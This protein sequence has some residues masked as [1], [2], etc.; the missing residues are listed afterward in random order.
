MGRKSFP[1]AFRCLYSNRSVPHLDNPLWI[2]QHFFSFTHLSKP[3]LTWCSFKHLITTYMVGSSFLVS[4]LSSQHRIVKTPRIG[5]NIS[6]IYLDLPQQYSKKHANRSQSDFSSTSLTASIWRSF[7]DWQ[8]FCESKK[9]NC[10]WNGF[11]QNNVTILRI[12]KIFRSIYLLICLFVLWF[13]KII[14]VIFTSH[15][16]WAFLSTAFIN[17]VLT[18]SSQSVL[19]PTPLPPLSTQAAVR[20]Y[21]KCFYSLLTHTG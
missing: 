4:C 19:C 18:A 7:D 5:A 13:F 11:I 17:A 14:I 3:T 12:I 6:L 8:P 10:E 21:M 2:T 9:N 15:H 16:L 20:P 1:A